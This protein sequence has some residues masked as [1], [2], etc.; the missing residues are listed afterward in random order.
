MTDK[1]FDL[2]PERHTASPTEQASQS[3]RPTDDELRR[4]MYERIARGN[5]LVDAEDRA[6]RRWQLPERRK[7]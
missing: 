4:Q 3:E 2:T 7:S 1:L 5:A 6:H